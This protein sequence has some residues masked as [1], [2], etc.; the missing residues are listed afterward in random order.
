MDR[1]CTNIIDTKR[2]I[3]TFPEE[4]SEDRENPSQGITHSPVFRL[5][6]APFED[7]RRSALS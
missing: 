2:I 5:K 6:E 7:R 3:S 4:S 1:V